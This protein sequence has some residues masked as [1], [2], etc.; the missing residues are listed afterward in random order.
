MTKTETHSI[1]VECGKEF[2]KDAWP[3]RPRITCS[4]T[5]RKRRRNR[6]IATWRAKTLCPDHLHGT[7]TGYCTYGCD[8]E[9]CKIANREYARKRRAQQA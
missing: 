9:P 4:D 2:D 8:C 5:C 7:I 3:G 6:Q 1:C